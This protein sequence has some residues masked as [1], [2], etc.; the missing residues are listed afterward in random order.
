MKRRPVSIALLALVLA[1]SGSPW[2]GAQAPAR[3][4]D[5]SQIPIDSDDIAGVEQSRP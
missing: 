4:G 3:E 1:G 2:L 5:R